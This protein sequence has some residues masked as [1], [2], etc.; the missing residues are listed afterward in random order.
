MSLLSNM[1]R[2][3]QEWAVSRNHRPSLSR[4]VE[5]ISCFGWAIFVGIVC[6]YYSQIVDFVSNFI[7]I[8]S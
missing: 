6:I 1:L 8:F 3:R 4:F 5:I 7:G 2:E